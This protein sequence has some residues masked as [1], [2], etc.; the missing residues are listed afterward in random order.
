MARDKA[1]LASPPGDRRRQRL[2]DAAV[3]TFIRFGFRKTSME[4]VARAADVSRQALY[5]HYATKEA[6]FGAAVRHALETG[7]EAASAKLGDPSLSL[8]E[9]LAGAFDAWVG[10]FVGI[11]GSDVGDLEEASDVVVGPLIAEHEERF[12]EA[13]A[14]AIRAS[15]L[16]RA[17]RA[18]GI[19]AKQLAETLSATARGLKHKAR[20]RA[21]FGERF[22]V[23]VRALCMPLVERR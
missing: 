13:V 7:L 19:G 23:A 6:L 3:T 12:V 20:S 14:K 16:P 22:G 17:Y 4:E 1:A 15:G 5:L 21:E 2:L 8:E 9:K 10:R 11:V 18:A